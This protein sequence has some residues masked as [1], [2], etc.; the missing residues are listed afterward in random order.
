MALNIAVAC[1]GVTGAL[2]VY[3]YLASADSYKAETRR[4]ENANLYHDRDGTYDPEH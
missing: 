1:I 4:G 2:F 3:F